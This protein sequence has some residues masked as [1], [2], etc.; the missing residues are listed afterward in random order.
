MAQ[1]SLSATPEEETKMSD[2]ALEDLRLSNPAGR[3]LP[4]L[5]LLALG[6]AGSVVVGGVSGQHW[7]LEI[8]FP[9]PPPSSPPPAR[10]GRN[11]LGHDEIRALI[12][13]AGAMCFLETVEAWD[14]AS[15]TCTTRTHQDPAHPLRRN[16]QLSA[17][18]LIEYGAQAMA[19]HGGLLA[20]RNGGRKAAPGMLTALRDCVLH[21]ERVDDIAAPLTV[22]ARKLF[23]SA[24]GW[25]YQFEISAGNEKLTEGRVSV[26]PFAAGTGA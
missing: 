24:S 16:G 7:K 6:E 14:D 23:A 17:V 1:L 11:L 8:S 2:A 9:P 18:H 20:R 21:V 15:V 25:M 3:A 22:I 13:H 12:P 10:R 26:I 4:P 19:V 5:R